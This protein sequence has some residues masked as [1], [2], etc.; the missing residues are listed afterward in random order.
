M[1]I[2]V[3]GAT[4]FVGKWLVK[5]LVQQ[6]NEV[7]ALIRNL[8]KTSEEWSEI[9]AI[10]CIQCGMSDY[11]GI[12]VENIGHVD[13]FYNFAWAA[14][15]GKDRADD[16]LQ[17]NNIQYACNAVRLA[18]RLGAKRFINAGSIM[19]Y[20]SF[21]GLIS[22][23]K[24]SPNSIYSI[25]KLTEDFMCKTLA[26]S[27]GLTYI[28]VIISNIYGVGETSVRFV[29]TTLRKM[30]NNEDID[31]SDCTQFYDFIY[32]SDAAEAIC[33][34]GNK[35]KNNYSY[36]IGN[37]EPKKL[38]EF[39]IQMRDSINSSSKLTFGVFPTTSILTYKEFNTHALSDEFGFKP[40][41][42]FPEGI[43]LTAEWILKNKGIQ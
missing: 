29:N 17:I 7:V 15:S 37:N 16:K 12:S 39:V 14:T 28:N 1:R 31:L 38:K 22:E 23:A 34:A 9:P 21:Y 33:L 11:E 3:T 13:A 26:N 27:L 40:K 25:A 36:Y 2:A 43:K 32:A 4:G 10:R 19:E 18:N 35:G 20:E 6:N 30:L 24:P 8:N 41:I 42:S 5:T